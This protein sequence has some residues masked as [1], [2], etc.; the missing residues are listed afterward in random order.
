MPGPREEVTVETE[1][2]TTDPLADETVVVC[3]V[4]CAVAPSGC[5]AWAEAMSSTGGPGG[6]GALR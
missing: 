2:R 1:E 6:G 3:V 5:A 4:V